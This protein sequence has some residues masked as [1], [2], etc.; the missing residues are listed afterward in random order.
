MK[1]K[2]IYNA[3]REDGKTYQEIADE[4][5]VTRQAIQRSLSAKSSQGLRKRWPRLLLWMEQNN[6][7]NQKIAAAVGVCNQTVGDWLYGI[8]EPKKP[9]IDALLK[10]TGLTYEELFAE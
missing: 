10:V 8:H 5:G 7:T 6:I 3:E 1:K 4:Y 9:N 2:D